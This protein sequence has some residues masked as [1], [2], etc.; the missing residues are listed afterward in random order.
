MRT[1][2]AIALILKKEGI[3]FLSAFPTTPVIEAIAESG[4][5][6]II[7]RQE[8][9]GVHIADGFARVTNGRK[10]SV[11]AMQYGPGAENA[12]PG[13]ATAFSDSV[14]MLFLPLGHPSSRESV[15]PMYSSLK[16][17]DSVTKHIERINTP[18]RA[19]ASLRRAFAA[20]R[21]G[22]PGPVMLEVPSDVAVEEVDPSIVDSYVPVKAAISAA[23][24]DD[25]MA[26][27]KA[28][29]DA[30][31]PLVIAGQGVLYAEASGELTELAELLQVAV[32]T[33]MAGKSA[34]PETHPLSVGSVSEVMNG[35]ALEYWREC[36]VLFGIGTSF[37]I[38]GMVTPIPAGKTIIH[39]TNNPEDLHKDYPS[40][41]PL[42]GDARL[43]L[44][45]MIDAC[46]E[47]LS[48]RQRET[49]DTA[50]RIS[51]LRSAWYG[52]WESK[53][54]SDESPITPYRVIGE[55]MKQVEPS[56]AIVTHDSGS[57][58]MQIMPFYRSDGPRSYIGW[59]KSHGLG[60]G[61]GL[62]MGAKLARP[63]KFCVNFMGDAAFGMTGLDF[64]TAV[65]SNIPICTI[66]LNN[67]DMAVEVPHM[68][69]SHDLFGSRGLY[70]RYADMARAM[71]GWSERVEDPGD[72]SAAILRARRVTEDGKPALL[73][74]VTS[75]EMAKSNLRAFA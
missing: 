17:Y 18:D 32:G 73:E 10:A 46:R 21:M 9:V 75:S 47:L 35:A 34:F 67:D 58:R 36:D 29:L 68:E 57:P 1:I 51:A 16:S 48:T 63:E 19:G 30:D 56:E 39:A 50:G 22:R 71:G 49:P 65:R 26:A 11:F 72:V 33:T 42:L 70:G 6:P 7:C 64:E 28:L 66:V 61:L 15:L 23:D 25:V 59:G 41:H 40:G 43:V 62:I 52:E 8:R 4:V 38:Q 55:F 14:P 54:T 27:A 45:Q 31:R 24:E 5:R 2:D 69:R 53:L 20:M 3:E 37:T 13:V 44:R 60:T 12:Y 74:F